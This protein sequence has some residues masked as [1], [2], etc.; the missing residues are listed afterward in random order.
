M[1]FIIYTPPYDAN[2]GGTLVLH[3][4]AEILQ[5]LGYSVSLWYSNK[6]HISQLASLNG[7]KMSLRYFQTR[8]KKTPKSSQFKE[9]IHKDI[10]DAV[11]I[12]PEVVDGNPL[13]GKNV[14]R[15]LLNKPGELSN[16]V[17]YGKDDL[18][19]FFDKHFN[20][21]QL[22]PHD[23][24]HLNVIELMGDIYKNTN[25]MPRSGTCFM[26]RKGKGRLLNQ[27]EE[28]AQQIDGMSHRQ[29]ASVFNHCKYF[30]SYDAY[31]MYSVYAAMCG[32]IPVVVPVQGVSKNEWHS[33]E[34]NRYGL[35]YGWDDVDWAVSTRA[36][37]YK[38]LSEIEIRSME[39]VTNFVS[40]CEE[41]FL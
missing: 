31:T 5:K 7:W 10:Q 41:Y 9:A 6:P 38:H 25:H 33:R 26:V 21:A 28:N 23:R 1:K 3:K 27:H 4:L 34:E 40:I 39:S 8:L 11:V 12:Y 24:N 16:K 32:C 22:N 37:L 30:V 15:W 35:A 20:D 29:I 18:F 13:K 36:N 19:F 17:E 14:V 2:S